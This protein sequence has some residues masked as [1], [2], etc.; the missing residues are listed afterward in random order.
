MLNQMANLDGNRRT[1]TQSVSLYNLYKNRSYECQVDM[2]GNALIQPLMY[3]N[4][5]NIPMFSGPYMITK[6]THEIS[7]GDFVT[8]F[9]GTRQPF[10][11]LPKID[12]F[13]QTL[14]VKILSTIQ[15]RIQ[16]NERAD[17]DKSENIILQRENVLSNVKAQETLTKNQ[18]CVANIN[19]RY[20]NFLGVDI[21]QQT[22]VP[23]KTLFDT[24]RT[25]LINRG[26][27]A[28]DS[29]TFVLSQIA[30]TFIYVDSGSGTNISGYENNYSTINLKEVYGDSFL[31]YV[32]RNYYCVTRGTNFNMPVASFTTFDNFIEFVIGKIVNIPTLINQDGNQFNL[33]TVKGISQSLAKQYVLNYPVNQ[34]NNVYTTLTEQDLLLLENEFL[35]A[36]DLFNSV[37]TFKV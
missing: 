11:S 14:N 27:K 22:T 7:D 16:Q 26:Y 19:S 3:F 21:P 32:K 1:S 35:K 8:N 12:N 15:S 31:N 24:I 17:R 20:R 5:R 9:T 34:P 33:N 36:I 10:Y 13:L 18:D 29:I 37:Q 4:I 30:F 23:V 2:M 25:K 6:V 28:T